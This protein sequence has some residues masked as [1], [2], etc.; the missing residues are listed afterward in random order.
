MK[1]SIRLNPVYESHKPEEVFSDD[2]SQVKK[3][4]NKRKV[5]E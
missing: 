5:V 3:K 1:E 2:E 4:R